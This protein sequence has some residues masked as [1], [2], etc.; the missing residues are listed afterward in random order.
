MIQGERE[1]GLDKDLDINGRGEMTA[2]RTPDHLHQETDIEFGIEAGDMPKE[3]VPL[4]PSWRVLGHERRCPVCA[5]DV[6]VL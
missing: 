4:L 3:M 5:A 2:V 1:G 6:D